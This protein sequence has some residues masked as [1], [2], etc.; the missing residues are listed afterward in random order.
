MEMKRYS[1]EYK[2]SIVRK[3]MPPE[4]VPIMRLAEE[5]GVSIVRD[6]G[7]MA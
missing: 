4:N 1:P 5:S 3:M 2:E 7:E 6:A